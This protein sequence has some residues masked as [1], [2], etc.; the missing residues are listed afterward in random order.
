[1]TKFSRKRL[2]GAAVP[3]LAAGPLARVAFAETEHSATH[4]GHDHVNAPEGH[5]AMIGNEAPSIGRDPAIDALLVPPPAL[6][7]KP[8]RVREYFLQ[9]CDRT[10]RFDRTGVPH[11]DIVRDAAFRRDRE[12]IEH[13]GPRRCRD[14][15][16]AKADSES[17][18][19]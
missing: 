13:L 1:M 6:P 3:L 8:G 11:V 15:V 10:A 14:V 16:N 19:V 2:L 17:A 5:A 9:C 4:E 7:H 18:F 12:K